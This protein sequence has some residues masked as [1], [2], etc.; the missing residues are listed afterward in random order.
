MKNYIKNLYYKWNLK[1]Q[2]ERAIFEVAQDIRYIESFKKDMLDYDE[3][4]ARKRM[5]EL[6]KIDNK[7]EIEEAELDTII[8]IVSQSKATKNEYEKS[9]AL[10]IDLENYISII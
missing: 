1:R 4:K 5:S 8:G 7:S 10:L 6:K 9:K 3:T 2:K